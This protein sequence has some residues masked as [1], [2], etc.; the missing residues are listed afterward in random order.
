[1]D[2]AGR[3]FAGYTVF[4]GEDFHFNYDQF[5]IESDSAK[6]FD[7]TPEPGASIVLINGFTDKP[8]SIAFFAIKS[9]FS[10]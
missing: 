10:T 5:N 1:M 9:I 3:L 6:Y 4:I 7:T 2:F 8:A